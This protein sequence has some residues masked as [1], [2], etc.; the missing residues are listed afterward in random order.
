MLRFVSYILIVLALF[1]CSTP[2][3]VDGDP[4]RDGVDG[5]DG[6]DG[7]P[8][9]RGDRGPAGA[10]GAQGAP[11]LGLGSV[12]QYLIAHDTQV[13]PSAADTGHVV[14]WCDEGDLLLSGGCEA[15]TFVNKGAGAIWRTMPTTIGC[16]AEAAYCWHCSAYP[17][18]VEYT[19]TAWVLCLDREER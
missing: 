19:L 5:V 6:A 17:G 13:I 2:V 3:A 15:P 11:G 14:S 12:D 18:E 1:A 8:G 4:G 10:P 7:A 16:P 9:P